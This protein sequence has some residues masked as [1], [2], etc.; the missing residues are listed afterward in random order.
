MVSN[1]CKNYADFDIMQGEKNTSPNFWLNTL[2]L[3]YSN[4]NLRNRLVNNLNEKGFEARP[5]WKLLNTLK[6]FKNSPHSNLK[7]ANLIEN[8]IISL[9]SG[10]DIYK[11]I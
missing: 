1:Y 7:N 5:V 8:K 10:Y 3:R 9:P 11:K 6:Q 4:Y 2:I